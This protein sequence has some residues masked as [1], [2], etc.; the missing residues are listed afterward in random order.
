[1]FYAAAFLSAFFSFQIQPLTSKALLPAFG[2]SYLVWGAC[3]VFYQATL[4]AAYLYAHA[5][6]RWLGVANYARLHWLLLLAPLL[7]FSSGLEVPSG[8]SGGLP[9]FL[10][11]FAILLVQVGFPVFVLST[12]SLVL[13]RWWAASSLPGRDNPYVL[14][15]ASNL[16]SML[17]LLTYPVVIEPLLKLENQWDLWR[18][19]YLLVVALQL[20]C[21]PFRGA[22]RP[23]EQLPRTQ[24][25][26]PAVMVR[27]FLLGMAASVLLLAVT[28]VI[29]LD[30]ASAPFLWVLPLSIYLLSFVV[31]FKS[32]PWYPVWMGRVI[33]LAVI[34]G[35]LLHLMVQLRLTVP[36]PLLI[37]AHLLILFILCVGCNGE[38]VFS[39]PENPGALTTFYLL[40][41]AGGLAGSI[42][43]NWLIPMVS[44]TFVEYPLAL[45][46][47]TASII[48]SQARHNSGPCS[49]GLPCP[50]LTKEPGAGKI[51]VM[52]CMLAVIFGGLGV[53]LLAGKFPGVGSGRSELMLVF[54]ALPVALALLRMSAHPWKFV[55]VLITAVISMNW[56]E[57][58]AMGSKTVLQFRNFYGIYKVTDTGNL[59]YLKHGSTLHGREYTSG[60]K[61]GQPLGYF[62]LTTPAAGVLT[63]SQLQ[64][65]NI[66]MIGLGT[67]AMAAYAKKGQNFTIFELDRD[68]LRVA[69]ENFTYLSTAKR[70]GA[71]V[72]FV[73]GDGR[74]SL[75]KL[76]D[77]SLDLLIVD[78]F[79]S[80][81][82]PVH[83]LTVE[84]LEEYFRVLGQDGLLLF[85]VSNKMRSL[86]SVVYS[87]ANVL[88]AYACEKSNMWELDPDAEFT[89]WMALSRNKKHFDLLTRKMIWSAA[90]AK[91]AGLPRPWTDQYSNLFGA[92]IAR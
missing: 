36:T 66:G 91:T 48:Y 46:I 27:Y 39:K 33:Y 8:I 76:K 65:K 87:G 73:F 1:M 32:K 60:P 82:I 44:T 52:V 10:S 49:A 72:D 86:V 18:A 38:L 59:R 58:L 90:D 11:V 64:F 53:P 78:A 47:V 50:P 43:V 92:M 57:T 28:N 71:K 56:T 83:L 12:T 9:L 17:G 61:V 84:A 80:G 2:G 35:V 69:E 26:A 55:L 88:G 13:Q 14:Y 45:V 67:G 68:N 24:S 40:I 42:I 37:L 6:Q 15:S 85:H 77:A 3:M 7:T 41:A 89:V 31:T 22:N 51:A 81:S 34:T 4:L 30:I 29:T 16:G 21:A 70:N 5:A 79:N 23:E 74:I 20:F 62:H 75:H 25:L 19:G 54:I 63:S